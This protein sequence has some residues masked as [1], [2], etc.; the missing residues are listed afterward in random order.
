LEYPYPLALFLLIMKC[1]LLHKSRETRFPISAGETKPQVVGFNSPS[2]LS[3][4]AS[5]TPTTEKFHE[6]FVHNKFF[7]T[8]LI[9]INLYFGLNQKLSVIQFTHVTIN[10]PIFPDIEF[11]NVLARLLI[12]GIAAG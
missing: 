11:A 3:E 9:L 2:G 8:S 10:S 12:N 4:R 5:F 6:S 7:Y 1:I